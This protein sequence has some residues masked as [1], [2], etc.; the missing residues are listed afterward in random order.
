MSILLQCFFIYILDTAP[1]KNHLNDQN[2]HLSY[3]EKNII[4]GLFYS[5]GMSVVLVNGYKPTY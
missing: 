4:V 3:A 1:F 5:I 2:H